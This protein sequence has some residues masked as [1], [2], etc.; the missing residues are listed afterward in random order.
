VPIQNNKVKILLQH[1][2]SQGLRKK[3]ISQTQ[4]SR[5]KEMEN[6]REEIN[7]M[8]IQRT[9]KI[10]SEINTWLFEVAKGLINP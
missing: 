10:I 8:E 2:E 4:N 5:W 1:H 7:G 9:T 3:R 6:I